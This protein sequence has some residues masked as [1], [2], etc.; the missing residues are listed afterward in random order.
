[1]EVSGSNIGNTTPALPKDLLMLA[2]SDESADVKQ[3]EQAAAQHAGGSAEGLS[4]FLSGHARRVMTIPGVDH[5]TILI[6][7]DA[8]NASADWLTLASIGHGSPLSTQNLL[9]VWFGVF[10]CASVSMLL[11]LM[12]ALVTRP[13]PHTLDPTFYAPPRR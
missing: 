9:F 12:V 2:G 6:S 7:P 8:L 5:T 11:L 13:R 10:L 4:N 1:V 3:A